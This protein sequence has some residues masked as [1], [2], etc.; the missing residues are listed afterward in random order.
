METHYADAPDGYF[1]P[2]FN[3][4]GSKILSLVKTKFHRFYSALVDVKTGQSNALEGPAREAHSAVFIP[5]SN[6]ILALLKG[7]NVTMNLDGTDVEVLVKR[8]D[9]GDDYSY[10]YDGKHIAFSWSGGNDPMANNYIYTMDANG[11]NVRRLTDVGVGDSEPSFSPDGKSIIFVSRRAGHWNLF[12]MNSDGTNVRALTTDDTQIQGP[13]FSPD[14]KHI[15]YSAFPEMNSW[16][17]F[18]MRSDGTMRK[19]LTKTSGT[20]NQEYSP[21]YSPNGK[22]IAFAASRDGVDGIYIMNSDGT[23]ERRLVPSTGSQL[24]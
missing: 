22:Q 19:A 3:P 1:T 2:Q 6:K 21:S 8:D 16:D 17:I 7:D 14:G 11:G 18:V 20:D 12:I 13:R 24:R 4:A 5:N 9:R 15:V 23:G 10:S